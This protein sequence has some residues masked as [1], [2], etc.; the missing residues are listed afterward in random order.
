MERVRPAL[1]AAGDYD[2]VTTGVAKVAELGNGAM[3]QQQAWTR[4]HDVRDVLAAVAAAT[5][6]TP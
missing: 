6:E 1:E 5:L 2:L 3:R 4:R